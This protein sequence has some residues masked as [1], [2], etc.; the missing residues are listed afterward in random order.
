MII[1]AI[2]A[3]A[4]NGLI[5]RDNN[6][7]WY[8]PADLK[9][10]KRTT[11]NHHVIMGRKTFESIG[12]PLPKRVNIILTRNPFYV[13]SNCVVVHSLQEALEVAEN[14]GE[15]EVFII[16]GSEI[17]QLSLPYLHRIYLTEVELEAPGDTYFPDLQETEWKVTSCEQHQADDK[18]QFNYRF[19]VLERQD[20]DPAQSF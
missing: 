8:L 6:I 1:S 16:G 3:V 12:R 14:N 5:G 2:V 11:L 13:A 15:S 17:Y 4:S 20:P 10:F 18:N 19:K 9:H 7:P